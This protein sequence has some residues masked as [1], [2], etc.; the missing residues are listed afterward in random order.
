VQRSLSDKDLA[1]F[2]AELQRNAK[3]SVTA[4][5]LW[6]FFGGL[7]GHNF[8]I[9]KARWGLIYTGLSIFSLLAFNA[10]NLSSAILSSGTL[11]L[12]L[13]YDLF[14]IPAQ[15][16]EREDN[17]KSDLLIQLGVK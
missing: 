6:L 8:Y 10:N 5:M 11:G 17:L 9:G 7:G 4:Y 16:R 2:N 14:T 13:L 12:L 1:I 15:I 3:N